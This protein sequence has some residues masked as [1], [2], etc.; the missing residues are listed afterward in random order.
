MIY[1]SSTNRN[2]FITWREINV[3]ASYLI[4]FGSYS[5]KFQAYAVTFLGPRINVN[6]TTRPSKYICLNRPIKSH[7]TLQDVGASKRK[8]VKK[9]EEKIP[10]IAL[11]TRG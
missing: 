5:I 9:R 3:L 11:I 8:K 4:G 1:G 10:K 2:R 7:V 6:Q